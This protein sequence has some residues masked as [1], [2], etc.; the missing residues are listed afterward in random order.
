MTQVFA[1]INNFLIARAILLPEYNPFSEVIKQ[2]DTRQLKIEWMMQL[3]NEFFKTAKNKY[4]VFLDRLR[5]IFDA[6][7]RAY[8]EAEEYYQFFCSGC[9]DSCCLTRFYHHTFLEYFYLL[10]GYQATAKEKQNAIRKKAATVCRKTAAEG[11][12]AIHVRHM[13]PLNFDGLCSLYAY[14]PMIC[15]M[16]GI[17][18][19]LHQPGKAVSYAPGCHVFTKQCGHKEYHPFDR[20]P[21][22]IELAKLEKEFK[23]DS[24]IDAKI[25]MTIAEMVMQF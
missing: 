5:E 1:L 11:Q 25:K 3:T 7:D 17:A 19:E 20:T 24:G 8:N 4:P 15:R 2:S 9:T 22:Y 23:Q 14:R 13:C 16:H 10:T 21:F 12:Q 18:H 6:M